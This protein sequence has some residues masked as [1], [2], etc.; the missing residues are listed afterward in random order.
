MRT[1]LTERGASLDDIIKKAGFERNAAIAAAKEAANENDETAQ[2]LRG[3]VPGGL[4]EI[5]GLHQHQGASTSYRKDY[6][7]INIV[8]KSLQ[9]D[10]EQADITDIIRAAPLGGRRSH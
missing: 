3:Y 4:Q 7:A 1:F 8:Y 5:Q 2:A 6:D 10:R 9:Q